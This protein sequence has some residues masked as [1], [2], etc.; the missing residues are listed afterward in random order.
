L[1]A[2]GGGPTAVV[3]SGRA[4]RTGP[5]CAIVNCATN[6]ISRGGWL[7]KCSQSSDNK[8]RHPPTTGGQ[9]DSEKHAADP[10]TIHSSTKCQ[11]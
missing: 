10:L 9:T 4:P 7:C 1:K 8:Q 6:K 2:G 11:W 5:R 3:I